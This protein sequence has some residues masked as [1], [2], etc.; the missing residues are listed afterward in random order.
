M[1]R[2]TSVGRCQGPGYGR[3][4][5]SSSFHYFRY[6]CVLMKDYGFTVGGHCFSVLVDDSLDLSAALAHYAPFASATTLEPVFRLHV[7]PEADLS[8]PEGLTEEFNQDDDGSQIRISRTRDG[9]N[10][11][12][13]SLRGSLSGRMLAAADF[14]EA[15]LSIHAYDDFALSNALMVQFA[16]A[17]APLR[18]ALFHAAVIGFQ[19]K[20][21]LFL[22]KSGTGKSTHA[23]L[24]LKH[25]AGSELV[26]DDNPV[27]R[28]LED[29]TARVYGSPWSG[30]TPCYRNI[31]LPVG[32]FVLLAQAPY[33][34]I[35]RLRGIAAYAALVPSISGKR[36]DKVIAD[37]LHETENAL[38]STV[39]VWHLDCLPDE[40]AARLSA[41]TLTGSER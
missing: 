38:A 4:W 30:K 39:P 23:R 12:A 34:A 18:T 14:S 21:Y 5:G 19:G 8:E 1:I 3:D 22:G 10:W 24:W 41:T 32:G 27:V 13:F 26:N 35:R 6:I 40:A 37:G 29:G 11:L 15:T 20:G 9:Q 17:T 36:W 2:S 16:M 28:I 25:I 7:V 33:N 31:D